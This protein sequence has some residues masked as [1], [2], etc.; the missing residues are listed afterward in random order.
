MDNNTSSSLSSSGI[1]FMGALQILLIGLKLG[2]VIDWAWWK[3]L[4]PLEID[5]IGGMLIL[6]G[7]A[8]LARREASR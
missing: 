6:M 1:G 5:I 8:I 4:L 2:H 3:V 7:F